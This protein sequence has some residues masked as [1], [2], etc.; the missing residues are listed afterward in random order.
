MKNLEKMT[1]EQKELLEEVLGQM[2]DPV[3][4]D[5]EHKISI[6]DFEDEDREY[7]FFID[8]SDVQGAVEVLCGK[9]G[10]MNG[11]W[12]IKPSQ[13]RCGRYIPKAMMDGLGQCLRCETVDKW[14]PSF[15][16]MEINVED[17]EF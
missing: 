16:D 8:G 10:A 3:I 7:I 17:L 12:E 9:F 6:Y 13:C 1:K 11:H 14:P 2:K 5:M 4:T 15:L